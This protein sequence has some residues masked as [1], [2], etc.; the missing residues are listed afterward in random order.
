MESP[1]PDRR[2]TELLCHIRSLQL[3]GTL[4]GYPH[5]RGARRLVHRDPTCVRR[6]L[7][8]EWDSLQQTTPKKDQSFRYVWIVHPH[9]PLAGQRV[10]AVEKK[11]TIAASQWVIPLDDQTRARIPAS[12]AVPDD[13]TSSPP[14]PSDGGLWADVTGLLRLARMV[15]RLRAVQPT[16]GGSDETTSI[17]AAGGPGANTAEPDTALLGQVATGTPPDRDHSTDDNDGQMAPGAALSTG[18][19]G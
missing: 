9:H 10:R 5:R 1:P 2:K 15:H 13:E 8:I 6:D 17:D 7:Y 14:V 4:E 19:G 3:V 12:W 16:E 18:G 11:G